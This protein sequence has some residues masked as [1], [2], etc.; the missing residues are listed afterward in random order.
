L[1]FFLCIPCFLACSNHSCFTQTES[2]VYLSPLS[3][4]PIRSLFHVSSANRSGFFWL[5]LIRI[6]IR[7]LRIIS[8]RIR[9]NSLLRLDSSDADFGPVCHPVCKSLTGKILS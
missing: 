8:S 5:V 4:V 9:S 7:S 2:F 6:L 3:S 1:Q